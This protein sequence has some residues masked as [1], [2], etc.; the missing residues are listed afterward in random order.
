MRRRDERWLILSL[1]AA[2]VVAMG[3]GLW[4]LALQARVLLG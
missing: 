4:S 1:V 2:S 3:L